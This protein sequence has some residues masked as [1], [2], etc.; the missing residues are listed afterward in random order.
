MRRDSGT[1][2]EQTMSEKSELKPAELIN[3][4]SPGLKPGQVTA[5]RTRERLIGTDHSVS[6]AAGGRFILQPPARAI[7]VDKIILLSLLLL[8]GEQSR[9]PSLLVILLFPGAYRCRTRN[10]GS[11]PQY[12][13][14]EALIQ[15]SLQDANTYTHISKGVRTRERF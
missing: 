6:S 4:H 1:V 11:V 3:K 14:S 13:Q 8:E 7:S 10:T 2:H 5:T 15:L 9:E 12:D